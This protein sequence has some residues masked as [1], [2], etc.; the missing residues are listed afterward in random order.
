M[1]ALQKYSQTSSLSGSQL[2]FLLTGQDVTIQASSHPCQCSSL[3]RHLKLP[4]EPALREVGF[5]PSLLFE[6]LSHSSFCALESPSLS[7]V[8]VISQQRQ[9]FCENVAKMV[10]KAGP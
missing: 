1:A 10:F 2:S 7:G 4:W 5:L 9:L 3:Y 6:Q 8:E